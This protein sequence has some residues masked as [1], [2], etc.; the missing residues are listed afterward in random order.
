MQNPAFNAKL[1][2]AAVKES[3]TVSTLATRNKVHPTQIYQWKKQLPEG[4]EA[5]FNDGTGLE[6]LRLLMED[7]TTG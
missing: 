5:V 2:L 6:E 3:E 7:L 4:L 1:A